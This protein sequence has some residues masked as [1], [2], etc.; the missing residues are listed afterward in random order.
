[1][2]VFDWFL[3]IILKVKSGWVKMWLSFLTW[4]HVQKPWQHHWQIEV[5]LQTLYFLVSNVHFHYNFCCNFDYMAWLKLQDNDT[6]SDP[7]RILEC[8]KTREN[9]RKSQ[10][11]MESL[12]FSLP[13]NQGFLGLFWTVRL[14]KYSS[15]PITGLA[16]GWMDRVPSTSA[17]FPASNWENKY[18]GPHLYLQNTLNY[19]DSFSRFNP[20]C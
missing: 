2:R 14:R 18:F 16:C 11:M 9:N 8:K 19:F 17:S 20:F 5:E 4:R 3:R 15:N 1:M 7:P 12:A 13:A 10:E 6:W